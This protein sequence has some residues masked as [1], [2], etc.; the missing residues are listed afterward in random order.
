MSFKQAKL[1]KLQKLQKTTKIDESSSLNVK[2]TGNKLQ[3]ESISQS[4]SQ[5]VT[6]MDKILNL[7]AET[8]HLTL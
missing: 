6:K 3:N 8:Q 7:I 5:S 2:T 4:V 1:Q